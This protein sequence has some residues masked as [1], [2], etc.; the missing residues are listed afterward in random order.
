MKRTVVPDGR[1]RLTAARRSSKST[2]LETLVN[3]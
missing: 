3:G 2:R 1:L